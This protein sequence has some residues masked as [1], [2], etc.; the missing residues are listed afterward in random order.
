VPI[1]GTSSPAL[2]AKTLFLGLLDSETEASVLLPLPA[3]S[4]VEIDFYSTVAPGAGQSFAYTLR[5]AAAGVFTG[6]DQAM[7]TTISGAT[8]KEARVTG[9]VAY[10][11]QDKFSVKLVTSASAA[12][13]MHF[14]VVKLSFS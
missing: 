5:K 13:A 10:S 4:I 14:A 6:S 9:S 12:Q 7:T 11:A 2:P 3:C 8:A 1:L